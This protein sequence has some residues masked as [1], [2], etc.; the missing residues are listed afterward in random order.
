M[1][2]SFTLALV[3]GLCAVSGCGKA[4][5][6][7]GNYRAIRMQFLGR[8]IDVPEKRGLEITIK[9]DAL[10]STGELFGGDGS[11]TVPIKT[12]PSKNPPTIDLVKKEDDKT[13]VI[14]GIY[15]LEGD[16][17]TIVLGF[18]DRDKGEESRPKDFTE[19]KD[20]LILVFK[21]K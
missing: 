12:D 16:E 15:K 9:G 21:R 2:V 5:S 8:S 6:I 18:K 19:S 4:P 11:G 14:R 20:V 13:E 17:L 10:T 3:A 7:E 1:R